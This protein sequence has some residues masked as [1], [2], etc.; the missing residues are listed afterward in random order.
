MFF[1]D[2]ASRIAGFV[3]GVALVL[4][5]ALSAAH[6][7][8]S[9]NTVDDAVKALVTAAKAD[10]RNGILTILGRS[11]TDI[12][13]SGDP[14]ADANTRARF[15]AAF[16]AKHQV[17]M[18][19]DSKAVLIIGANEYPFPI[20][21]VRKNDRW[22]FD[23]QAGRLEILY[24]RIGRNELAAIQAA[25]AYVDA[26]NE[27]AEK[28]R[29]GAGAGT[30]AQRIVSR[31]GKKDG[32]YWPAAQGEDE[33]PLGEVV[34]KASSDGY[35]LTGQRAPFHG[36]YYRVLTRQGPTAPGGAADYVVRGKMMGGFALVAYP[37]EYGNS[38]VMTFLVNHE[39]I[40]Y[41][42]DLGPR[43]ARI[44]GNMTSFNP[45]QTWKKVTVESK[46]K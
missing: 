46:A 9:F 31:S 44:A 30:Y 23:T 25:L 24:R 29:A 16:D 41:Q 40:V 33:S 27:Y 4:M 12:V 2:Q 6:A 34:A 3:A 11:G 5:G 35:R 7:Q 38:G 43:T 13:S 18:E 26:Q 37:A 21:L 32:L 28:D 10:S 22:E 42:K 19:G 39:G 8:Q 15:V 1:S 45:D 36:Y 14:V 20:P 17:V